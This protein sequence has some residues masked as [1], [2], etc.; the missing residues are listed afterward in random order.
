MRETNKD[1]E[2][3]E[4]ELNG[5]INTCMGFL[6]RSHPELSLGI[7]A[8]EEKIYRMLFWTGIVVCAKHI[9]NKPVGLIKKTTKS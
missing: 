3:S 1:I 6:A 9:Y 5:M 7:S 2:F 4:E 8:E